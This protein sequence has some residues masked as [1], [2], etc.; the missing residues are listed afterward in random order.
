MQTVMTTTS[1]A[2]QFSRSAVRHRLRSGTWQQPAPGVV[3]AHNASLTRE[4]SEFVALLAAP[5]GSALGGLTA[6]RYDGLTSLDASA[7]YVIF[8]EGRRRRD[9]N[10][11]VHFSTMLDD[12]D[13]HP[14]REPRRTR[15][16]RSVCDAAT[17]GPSH[18]FARTVVLAA[19]QQGLVNLR[20][21]RDALSRR[22]KCKRRSVIIQSVLDAHGGMRS[23]PERDFDEIRRELG[24]PAPAR[25][26]VLQRPDGRYYLDADWP[27]FGVSVEIHGTHHMEVAQ[28]SADLA[29][30]NEV[31]ISGRQVLVFTSFAIRH[32][33]ERVADQLTRLFNAR[34]WREPSGR[35]IA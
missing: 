14:W 1:A 6:L 32:E 20:S 27:D 18:R 7:T 16:A 4:E 34:G 28:W 2:R 35:Q 17:W 31:T 25:Q 12:R 9:I 33:R 21:M 26:R 23:L 30:G 8:P 5:P 10:A 29:R 24:L 11:I 22:G 15:P 19:F 3:V 13:V